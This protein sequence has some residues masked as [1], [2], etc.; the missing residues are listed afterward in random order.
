MSGQASLA[1]EADSW[2]LFSSGGTDYDL[3]HLRGMVV[4]VTPKAD[5]ARTYRVL[6]RFGFH[7]FTKEAKDGD[8]PSLHIREGSETRCFCPVRYNASKNL[9]E[10]FRSAAGGKAYFDSTDRTY[11]L[12][13][14]L[15]GFSGPYAVFFKAEKASSIKNIDVIIFVV[16][17]YEKPKLPQRLPKITF[18]TLVANVAAGRPVKRPKK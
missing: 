18:A 10:I 17:A 6:I 13:E 16:S 15:E 11:L 5:D 12:V 8:D 1:G 2:P 14:Q 3:D 4:E 7:T 9:R